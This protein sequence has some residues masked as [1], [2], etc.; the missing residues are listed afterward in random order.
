MG[1]APPRE[2]HITI[3]RGMSLPLLEKCMTCCFPG[4][5]HCPFCTPAY[6]KPAKRSKVLLHLEFH[7]KRACHV[8]EYTVHKCSLDCT[9]RPHYHCLYCIAMLGSKH[10]F[11]KHIE[12]CQE[13][14]N[15]DG[16]DDDA[17]LINRAKKLVDGEKAVSSYFMETLDSESED[18]ALDSQSRMEQEGRGTSFGGGRSSDADAAGKEAGSGQLAV[19]KR[20]KMLQVNLDK[21]QDC[22]EFYF[23]NLVKMFKQLSASKKNEV[24]MKIER[25]LFEA[26]FM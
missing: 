23:M 24:R 4:L 18:V 11:N 2:L 15:R 3:Q 17:S 13:M 26:E 6:F 9:K 7:L 16:P 25:I 5:Y 14:Q 12:F 19:T 22:D 21:P 1:D 8:G 10:D 20:D